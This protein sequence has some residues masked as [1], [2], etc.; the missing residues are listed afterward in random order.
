M[1]N[2]YTSYAKKGGAGIAANAKASKDDTSLFIVNE[3]EKP[4]IAAR[5]V[6]FSLNKM[7][8]KVGEDFVSL[9][10]SLFPRL[11]IPSTAEPGVCE[12]H[13]V[14]CGCFDFSSMKNVNS[15]VFCHDEWWITGFEHYS[16]DCC[17]FEYCPWLLS[18]FRGFL[19]KL[20]KRV[21]AARLQSITKSVNF[22]APSLFL[23][24]K[25]RKKYG[26]S[27]V[28]VERNVLDFP[29][30]S[31]RDR[32]RGVLKIL[33]VVDKGSYYRKGGDISEKIVTGLISSATYRKYQLT[34]I[35]NSNLNI[36]SE[37][38]NVM[39]SLPRLEFVRALS[40]FDIVILPTRNDN[41]PNV[42]VEALAVG[43]DVVTSRNSG[44]PELEQTGLVTVI[45][46]TVESYLWVVSNYA[47]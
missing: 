44:L 14:H 28:T 30:L 40:S 37:I 24:E 15:Y 8:R 32:S 7:F 29:V 22:K 36:D 39:T 42:G 31:R 12:I 3:N 35:G 27:R 41:L 23:A 4:N 43:V 25:L 6:S 9:P 26:D 20:I 18:S 13:W 10:Y 5:L 46:N 11:G 38:V 2:I 19:R 45:D 33:F 1:L 34:I 21:C 47:D 17:D 16:S